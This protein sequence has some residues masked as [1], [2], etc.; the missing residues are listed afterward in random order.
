MATLNELY[1]VPYNVLSPAAYNKYNVLISTSNSDQIDDILQQIKDIYGKTGSI[2]KDLISQIYGYYNTGKFDYLALTKSLVSLAGLIPEVAPVVPFVNQFIEFVWPKVFGGPTAPPSIF[3]QLKPQ[4]QALVDDAI[5]KQHLQDLDA[6]ATGFQ[7]VVHDYYNAVDTLKNY[8]NDSGALKTLHEEIGI[9]Q[10]FFVDKFPAFHD[11]GIVAMPY[12]A[13]MTTIQLM[14]LRTAILSGPEWGLTPGDKANYLTQFKESITKQSNW[15]YDT[16][17]PNLF[18]DNQGIGLNWNDRSDL[19]KNITLTS[20]DLVALWPTLHPVNYPMET[21]IEFTR[22]ITSHH[23]TP[24]ES[25]GNMIFPELF[26][27][28]ELSQLQLSLYKNEDGWMQYFDR[29]QNIIIDSEGQEHT[30]NFNSGT[31]YIPGTWL[32]P[33]PSNPPR[34]I[35]QVN[36]YNAVYGRARDGSFS[37]GY[38][39][40]GTDTI[41]TSFNVNSDN[42]HYFEV[43]DSAP[44]QHKL[45]YV[46]APDEGL[47]D[48]ANVYIPVNTP[49]VNIIGDID[50]ETKQP[51]SQIKGFPFEKNSY[52]NGTVVREWVNGANAIKL[53]PGQSIGIPIT[54]ITQ[55]N[56]QVRCRYAS[57]GPNDIFF[58]LDTGGANPI[59][60][61]VSFESTSN[62]GVGGRGEQGTYVVKS[63]PTDDNSVTVNLPVKTFT[64]HLTNNG[65]SDLFLDR[66]EFVPIVSDT[67]DSDSVNINSTF[68]VPA[69]QPKMVWSDDTKTYNFV[70][71]MVEAA[72]GDVDLVFYKDNNVISRK[73]FQED[74]F[75]MPVPLKTSLAPFNKLVIENTDGDENAESQVGITGTLSNSSTRN[76]L[77]TNPQDLSNITTQVNA[78]FASS[79]QDALATD[80]SDYWIEQVVLKVDALS[81][82]VFGKEK[83]AL[84]KLVNTAKRL[85]KARNL[86]V[87]GNFDNFDAWYRGRNVV[88]ASDH[89]LFKSDHVLLPPPALYPSY[90]FQKVEESKLKPNTRYTVSGFIAHAEDLEIVISR[91]GQEIQKVVQVPYGEAFPL[92]SGAASSCCI[93][94]S[95]RDGK[96]A[97]P[98]LFSYSIDVGALDLEANPGIE[99]GLRIVKP[100]GMARVSNLEVREERPL[101]ASEMRKVQRAARDWRKVYDKERADVTALL[102]PV[103][104]QINALY[105]N[106]NWNG[107]IRS[108]ITY[109]D[110]ESIILPELSTL[111][112]WFMSDRLGEQGA[113][114]ERFQEA[115]DRAYTQLEG[116]T[117]LHNGHF[118]S[119]LTN[120][121]VEGD[122]HQTILSDGRRVLRLPD[123]SSSASQTIEIEN[124]DPDQEYQLNVH[125][126]GEGSVTLQHGETDENV[127]VHV[128]NTNSFTTSISEPMTLETNQVTVELTS[129]DGE[130]LVDHIA[131]VAVPAE[132]TTSNMNPSMNTAI[133]PNWNMNRNQ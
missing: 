88:R 9:V 57:N 55:Q 104:N 83:K 93:P 100:T 22:T 99:I 29:L 77:F 47:S 115:L 58:N 112:H 80:V 38:I 37:V 36:Y 86:L 34:M 69:N 63:I 87:G 11:S 127:D 51:S 132:G 44:T 91:Y 122:T 54:N 31:P 70:D 97:D 35:N 28:G 32:N 48:F 21:N 30:Y 71:L 1:P 68:S 10:A 13:Q 6:A 61:T 103:L 19:I 130:F 105:V 82:D 123:W 40:G 117:L 15:V 126:K 131:L 52:N 125:A 66:I 27:L 84:R 90:I 67:G 23:F 24:S 12:I 119:D 8:P 74:Y 45:N 85:S 16:L 102:Q 75:S 64:V 59:F 60:Q 33:F 41:S 76:M 72:V 133:T 108:G 2:P 4:I 128:H 113:V 65:S 73:H 5:Y 81:N 56:Y 106:G 110:L 49:A 50:S 96:P 26:Y 129:E 62:S 109:R 18:P 79:A 120:W 7:N 14:I 17:K 111:R 20:L 92:T 101:K 116:S 39:D 118:T 46:Y 3:E 114:L 98:H 107:A 95:T 78:L 53:S 42:A 25:P 89:E 121:T 124:F 43:N 94:R